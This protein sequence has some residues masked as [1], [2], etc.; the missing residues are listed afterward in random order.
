MCPDCRGAERRL[1]NRFR[2]DQRTLASEPRHQTS[3]L[4]NLEQ[5]MQ[6]GYSGRARYGAD[7]CD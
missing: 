7:L 5:E 6:R 2:L 4:F 3:P 1:E